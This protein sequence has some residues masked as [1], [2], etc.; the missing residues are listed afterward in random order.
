MRKCHLHINCGHKQKSSRPM[1]KCEDFKWWLVLWRVVWPS[2][3]RRGCTLYRVATKEFYREGE[4]KNPFRVLRPVPAKEL[5]P[6]A[7]LLSHS[8]IGIIWSL[9][10]LC[11]FSL[12]FFNMHGNF[13]SWI[14]FSQKMAEAL[15]GFVFLSEEDRIAAFSIPSIHLEAG[16]SLCGSFG[17]VPSTSGLL[18]VLRHSLLE[19]PPESLVV[20]QSPFPSRYWPLIFVSCTSQTAPNSTLLYRKL[21]CRH[22]ACCPT[23]LQIL[24]IALRENWLCVRLFSFIPAH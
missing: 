3:W 1:H 12:G 2:A 14:P 22:L 17:K 21:L 18:R 23:Q 8:N 5:S 11:A 6:A 13:L 4:K 10:L 16:R 24:T 19:I 9:L 20:C 7:S 15:D